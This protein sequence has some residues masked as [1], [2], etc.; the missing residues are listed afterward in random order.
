MDST[1]G[2]TFTPC[3]GYF[4]SRGMDTREISAR[5]HKQT[6]PNTLP[7]HSLPRTAITTPH[8]NE[9]N[10]HCPPPHLCLPD[11]VLYVDVRLLVSD[12]V[13]DAD[14]VSLYQE[15]VVDDRLY[16]AVEGARLL[17]AL[18]DEDDVHE[19]ARRRAQRLLAQ[20]AR[21]QRPVLHQHLQYNTK[22]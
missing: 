5:T 1:T 9:N 18:L 4:T 11:C 6:E 15:P 17:V 21:D 10:L 20:D 2:Y 7:S 19:G 14:R 13:P 8:N 22:Q 12:R 16:V 3:V